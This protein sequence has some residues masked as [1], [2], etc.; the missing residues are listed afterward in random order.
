MPWSA[1]MLHAAASAAEPHS[2]IVEKLP[3]SDI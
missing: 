3:L 1:T 2:V